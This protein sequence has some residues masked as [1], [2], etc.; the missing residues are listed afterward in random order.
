ML[1]VIEKVIFLQNVDVFDHVP[2]EQ[3]AY[4]AAVAEEVTYEA[5]TDVF[6][7]D[8]PSDSLYLILEGQVR[9]H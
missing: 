9:L 8:D 4:L 1:T 2:T 3:L 7:E 5:G 6:K